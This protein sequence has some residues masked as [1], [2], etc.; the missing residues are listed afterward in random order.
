MTAEI[1]KM[2]EM[3]EQVR[4]GIADIAQSRDRLQHQI[5]P[6]IQQQAK[7]DILA[8]QARQAGRADLAC[9]AL[10]RRTFAESQISQMATQAASLKVKEAEL[11]QAS[12]RLQAKA[13]GLISRLRQRGRRRKV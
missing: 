10:A 8:E 7:L 2:Q 5:S 3:I 13:D 12:E 6:T 1:A 4:V 11:S 9:D